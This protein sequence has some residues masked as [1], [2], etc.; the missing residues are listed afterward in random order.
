MSRYFVYRDPVGEW[1]VTREICCDN[2]EHIQSYPTWRGAATHAFALARIDRDC[3]RP[4]WP[5]RAEAA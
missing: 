4:W 1:S 3:Y 2:W 5:P